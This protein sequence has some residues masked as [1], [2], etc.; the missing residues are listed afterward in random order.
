MST[1]APHCPSPGCQS[2]F[3]SSENKPYC[4]AT[5]FKFHQPSFSGEHGTRCVHP[6]CSGRGNY[7]GSN[8]TSSSTIPWC[9][10]C[11]KKQVGVFP[12]GV[13]RVCT[14]CGENL[15]ESFHPF[16]KR[17]LLANILQDR[18]PFCGCPTQCGH[19]PIWMKNGH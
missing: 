10:D 15:M 17:C 6:H 1:S 7:E 19:P 16:C 5:C 18:S 2:P 11:I 13:C 8:K 4:S 3:Q 9:D 14:A 12:P